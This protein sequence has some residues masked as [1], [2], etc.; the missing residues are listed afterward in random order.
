MIMAKEASTPKYSRIR[1]LF[2]IWMESADG[3]GV[4]DDGCWQLLKSI[5]QFHSLRKAS[6]D[7]GIS[8]RKA[9]GDLR[10]AEEL[11]G[12]PLVEK[13]RGGSLGGETVL[14][15]E[16]IRFIASYT[17]FYEEFTAAVDPV[18]IKLKRSLKEKSPQR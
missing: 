12:F 10:R 18:I 14:T 11:L 1:V 4:L 2:R 8:Y 9:W 3:K 5:D 7:L 13:H 17:D 16:G 15:P 6:T